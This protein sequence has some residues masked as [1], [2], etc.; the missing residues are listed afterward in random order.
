MS[1]GEALRKARKASGLN[2]TELGKLVGVGQTHITHLEKGTR[3]VERDPDIVRR[4]EVALRLSPGSLADELPPDSVAAKLSA[5]EKPIPCV[6]LVSAG[7]GEGDDTF[8]EPIMLRF[9]DTLCR[10]PKAFAL[11][12]RG[13]SMHQFGMRDGCYLVVR[14]AADPEELRHLVLQTPEGRI[15]KY[16]H[17]GYLISAE[18]G[19]HPKAFELDEEGKIVGVVETIISK[20]VWEPP[21]FETMPAP[22]PIKKRKRG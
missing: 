9:P 12:V 1:F 20:P 2:Q 19:A 17:R 6:G 21:Q 4:L 10:H 22:K 7:P 16:Y 15:V 18:L 5:S 11:Q 8:D 14:P 13:N 3:G